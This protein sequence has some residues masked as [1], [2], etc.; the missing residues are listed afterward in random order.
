MNESSN[1]NIYS[2]ENESSSLETIKAAYCCCRLFY[3]VATTSKQEHRE[4][5]DTIKTVQ[6][7]MD[8]VNQSIDALKQSRTMQRFMKPQE[9]SNNSIRQRK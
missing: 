5:I 1:S 7:R 2:N 9:M 8:T 3:T 4:L 6:R